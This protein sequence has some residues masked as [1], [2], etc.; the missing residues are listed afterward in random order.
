MSVAEG[1][2]LRR[3]PWARLG[4][5]EAG[6]SGA[7]GGRGKAGALQGEHAGRDFSRDRKSQWLV[8]VVLVGLESSLAFFSAVFQ[9]R[10]Q[11]EPL[12]S[13]QEMFVSMRVPDL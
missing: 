5:G 1:G 12:H 6:L 3:P 2:D 9:G 10:G 8:C 7:A 11:T 13:P 4:P